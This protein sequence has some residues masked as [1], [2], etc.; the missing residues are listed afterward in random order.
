MN[1]TQYIKETQAELKHV[2]WPNRRELVT[3]TISVIVVSISV[4]VFLSFADTLFKY[5]LSFVIA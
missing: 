4:A 5:L 1:I 3:Y 2:S